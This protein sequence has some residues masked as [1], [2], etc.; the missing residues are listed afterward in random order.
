M[1]QLTF[2]QCM[3][4]VEPLRQGRPHGSASETR[5]RVLTQFVFPSN[6]N[7]TQLENLFRSMIITHTDTVHAIN[8]YLRSKCPVFIVRKDLIKISLEHTMFDPTECGREG[9][10]NK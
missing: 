6:E 7:Q 5:P 8:G 10:W 9:K 3:A 4:Y 1:R 2:P